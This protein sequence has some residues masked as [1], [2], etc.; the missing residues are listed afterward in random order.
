MPNNYA[1]NYAF[2]GTGNFPAV[3]DTIAST[4]NGNPVGNANTG[5]SHMIRRVYSSTA[6][7]GPVVL[8]DNGQGSNAGVVLDV[9]YCT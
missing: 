2:Y 1:G 6:G 8:I 4:Y 5:S 3:G 7:H 9:H